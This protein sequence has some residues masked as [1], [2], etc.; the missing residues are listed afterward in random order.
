MQH[1]QRYIYFMCN[2]IPPL[3]R[4]ATEIFNPVAYPVLKRISLFRITNPYNTRRW[5]RRSHQPVPTLLDLLKTYPKGRGFRKAH[6]QNVAGWIWVNSHIVLFLESEAKVKRKHF[7]TISKLRR[8]YQGSITNQKIAPY[9]L[10]RIVKQ[11]T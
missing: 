10:Y 8:K 11:M 4:L 7:N 6:V 5:D 2:F 9:K 3:V 1:L